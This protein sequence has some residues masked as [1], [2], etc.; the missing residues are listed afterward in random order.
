ML[1]LRRLALVLI[2]PLALAACGAEPKWASDDD[3]RRS[4]YRAPGA[5]TL[6]LITAIN[7]RSGAGGHSALLVSGQH[8]VLFDP[9]GTWWH[10][11]VPERNDVLFGMTPLMLE[12]YTD[13][14]ARA[15]YHV[16]F[17]EITVT[18][19]T[20][21][22]ALQLVQEHGPAAKAMCGQS[23]SGILQQLGFSGIRRSYYP[24]KIMDDFANVPGVRERKVFDD[25]PDANQD[26]LDAQRAARVAEILGN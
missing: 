20:A 9:A 24:D 16:V 18:P 11:T 5:P 21:A 22:L 26:I 12:Y 23:V 10:P 13:Y 25:S 15:T 6:T 17:Q 2:L 19:E 1:F 7:N 8:R 4:L 3:V 14:H